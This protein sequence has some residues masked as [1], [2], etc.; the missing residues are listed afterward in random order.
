MILLLFVQQT[1]AGFSSFFVIIPVIYL[2]N[3]VDFTEEFNVLVLRIVFVSVHTIL[4]GVV[5]AL[6]GKIK[7]KNDRTPVKPE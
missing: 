6:Y 1:M 2:I 7:A 5:F 4:G 3:Q